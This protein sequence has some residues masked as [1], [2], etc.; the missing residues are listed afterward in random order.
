M[1]FRAP[2][3]DFE[4]PLPDLRRRFLQRQ[5]EHARDDLVPAEDRRREE[6]EVRREVT[7]EHRPSEREAPAPRVVRTP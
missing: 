2:V 6:Q 7:G 4:A 3:L 5:P 1:R